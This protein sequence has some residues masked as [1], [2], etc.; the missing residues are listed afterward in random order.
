[1]ALVG[2][3]VSVMRIEETIELL[4]MPAR[5]AGRGEMVDVNQC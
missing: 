1:M 3:C 2:T 5:H 4:L